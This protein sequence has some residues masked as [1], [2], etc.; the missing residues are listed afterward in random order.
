M[1]ATQ[2]IRPLWETVETETLRRLDEVTLEQL[3][4]DA[5]RKGLAEES[6]ALRDFTI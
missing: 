4:D 1:L 3:C 5:R 6:E 2:V